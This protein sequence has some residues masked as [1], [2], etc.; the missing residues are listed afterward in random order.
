MEALGES[1]GIGAIKVDL[2]AKVLERS[3]IS[4]VDGYR[5]IPVGVTEEDGA[6]LKGGLF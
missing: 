4:E 1:C 3:G 2:E 6:G 5:G